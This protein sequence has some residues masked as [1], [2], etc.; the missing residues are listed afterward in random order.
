MS[1]RAVPR[2]EGHLACPEDSGQARR[3]FP[4]VIGK[5]LLDLT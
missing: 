3:H 1:L 4:I 5:H 2:Y